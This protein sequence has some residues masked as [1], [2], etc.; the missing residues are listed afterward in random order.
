MESKV[1]NNDWDI[2]IKPK[3]SPFQLELGEIW[4][5]R[6]LLSLLV[7]RDIVAQYKQTVLGPIWMFIQPLLSTIV[8]TITFGYIAKIS[9]DGIPSMLFYIIG[10]TFWNYFADCLSK[11]SS[12]FISNSGV[13]GKVYFPRLIIPLSIIA[14]NVVKLLIQLLLLI[15]FWIYFLVNYSEIQPHYQLFILIPFLIVVL[16]FF[17]LSIGVIISSVTTKY[18]DITFLLGF[19]IQFIMYGSCIIFPISIIPDRFK[20]I[21]MCNP[22][23]AIVESIRY[24]FT[25]HGFF[26]P[27]YLGI[28]LCVTL[29]TLAFSIVI[30]NRTEKSFMDTV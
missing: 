7:K 15:M 6:D 13:F 2:I 20:G 8:Y 27:F 10:L 3:S 28:A 19:G 16:A 17:G 25:G 1:Q 23:A 14:A 4:R 5:Y 9:T 24:I 22:V 12:T 21:L 18:R 29:V 30:F 11:T 26:S